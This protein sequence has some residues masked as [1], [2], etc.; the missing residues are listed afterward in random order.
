[1]N[2]HYP[3]NEVESDI[4]EIY[5]SAGG[6]ARDLPKL[7]KCVGGNT[8]IMIGIQYNKYYPTE[9]FRLPNGLS[10]YESQFANPDG[11]RGI[12]GG[13]HKVFTKIHNDLGAD[14]MSMSA[15][16]SEIVHAYCIGFKLSLDFSL[17]DI[18][19]QASHFSNDEI[20][21]DEIEKFPMKE[22]KSVDELKNESKCKSSNVFLVKNPSKLKVLKRLK[23][24]RRR[25]RTAAYGAED[26]KTVKIV[27]IL[28]ALAYRKRWNRKSLTSVT[29]NLERGYTIAKLPFLCDPVQKLAPNKNIAQ[30]IYFGQIKKLNKNQKDKQ[31][32]I[33]VEKKLQDLGFVDFVDN[34][35]IEQQNK[36]YSSKLLYY[37]PW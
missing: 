28:S 30:R 34:L 36:I 35:T 1:M 14:H 24:L 2:S 3:L 20:K 15:Y 19:E 12:V 18:K 6:S 32:V 17:L 4:R 37:M 21:F 11:S 25:Y 7:P 27:G 22:N 9:V 16:I 5:A 13:P 23:Q 8:G 33:M 10:I 29:V 31:D 26:V